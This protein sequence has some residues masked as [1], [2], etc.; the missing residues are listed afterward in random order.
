MLICTN[1]Y[2]YIFNLTHNEIEQSICTNVREYKV[3]ENGCA[4]Y[5]G[6]FDRIEQVYVEGV[7]GLQLGN[8]WGYGD[9][10]DRS[11]DRNGDGNKNGGVV[12]YWAMHP[13]E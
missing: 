3:L 1:L 7:D 8:V 6:C 4:L 10:K 12:C 11:G 13:I 9:G 2:L 5:I